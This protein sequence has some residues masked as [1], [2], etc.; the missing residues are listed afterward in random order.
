MQTSPLQKTSERPLYKQLMQRLKNDIT[1][2]VYPTGVRIPGEQ[3]LCAAYGVSRVTVRKAL[4]EIVR[5]GLLVR[6][7]GKGTFVAQ[8]KIKRDL[9]HITSFSDAC[10]QI[11]QTAHTRLIERRTETATEEDRAKLDLQIGAQVLSICRLRLSDGK[12]V[13]LEY[14]RFPASLKFLTTAPLS[15]SLYALLAENGLIPSRAVH[16]ISLGRAGEQVGKLLGTKDGDALLRLDQ[17]VF[18]QHDHPLHIS[19][20]WIRGDRFT[21]RI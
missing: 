14:N 1:A 9:A 8:E 18:D 16:D 7:Q 6:R 12:P 10:A 13:M 5:E 19:C 15:G 20:Q 17:V 11:G 2:G 3:A 21:F 4:E